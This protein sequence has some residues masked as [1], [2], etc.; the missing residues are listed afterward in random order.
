MPIIKIIII[1]IIKL[2]SPPKLIIKLPNIPPEAICIAPANPFATPGLSGVEEIAPIKALATVIPLDNPKNNIG[3]DI[4]RGL[5]KPYKSNN[6]NKIK[7]TI[8]PKHPITH[9]LE[10]PTF[11]ANL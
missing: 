6:N 8:D 9:I 10:I 11:E 5:L 1:A 4:K 3:K 7:A 2:L